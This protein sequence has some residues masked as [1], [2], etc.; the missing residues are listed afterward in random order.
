V[1]ILALA[2]AA[3]AMA[4]CIVLGVVVDVLRRDVRRH[5]DL[6][7]ETDDRHD[8]G[9]END[10]RIESIV[11]RVHPEVMRPESCCGA[12]P[13]VALCPPP[14]RMVGPVEVEEGECLSVCGFL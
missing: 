6:I 9:I 5:E 2:L 14:R 11:R 3:A 8:I 13:P 4:G 7:I 1:T 12:C 10:Q